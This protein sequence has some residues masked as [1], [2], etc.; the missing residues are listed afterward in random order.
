MTIR[1]LFST[2]FLLVA[3]AVAPCGAHAQFAPTPDDTPLWQ[4]NFGLQV[5]QLLRTDDPAQQ[6]FAMQLIVD[7][8]ETRNVVPDAHAAV[9]RILAIYRD[10]ADESRRLLALAALSAT[11]DADAMH[12]LAQHVDLEASPRVKDATLAVLVSYLRGDATS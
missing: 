8:A 7:V 1:R 5:L 11:R 10:D 6:D 2:L 4:R 3:V 12:A 9:P